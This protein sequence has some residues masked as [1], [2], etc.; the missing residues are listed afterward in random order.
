MEFNGFKVLPLEGRRVEPAEQQAVGNILEEAN[1]L[2]SIPRSS[3]V[4]VE[5]G[6][7]ITSGLTPAAAHNEWT[8]R[9][10]PKIETPRTLPRQPF[11]A[12][13]PAGLIHVTVSAIDKRTPGMGSHFGFEGYFL[14]LL[15]SPRE[16]VIW[17]A[18]GERAT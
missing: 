4:L 8:E 15:L 9:Y 1:L 12:K 2:D 13:A 6:R 11:D 7:Q 5:V 3:E 14:S 17:D 16:K 10:F 18:R